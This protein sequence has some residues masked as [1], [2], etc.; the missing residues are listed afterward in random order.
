M[1]S[2]K[3]IFLGFL[4]WVF[5]TA[6]ASTAMAASTQKSYVTLRDGVARYTEY[7]PPSEGQPTVILINGLVYDLSRWKPYS[8]QL[9][10]AGFGVLNYYFRGQ[11]LTLRKEAL[12]NHTP[13][14]F[15]TGLDS[16]ALG[17]ELN[18]L[19]VQ[20]KL[21][22]P[23]V[24]V[25]LSY[26]SNIAAQFAVQNPRK[27]SQLVLMSPL[28]QPLSNYDPA[29]L[30]L[31]WNLEQI[32][33]WWGPVFGPAFYEMA[34]AQIY[35]SYLLQR[36][37]P[38]RI[39]KELADMP[40]V[41]KES[42]F[43]LVRAV[44]DFDLKKYRFE[45]LPKGSVHFL[46]GNEDNRQMFTDQIKAFNGTA[47]ASKGSL[48]YLAAANHAIPD[49]QGAIAAELTQLI[50]QRDSRLKSGATYQVN[51]KGQLAPATIK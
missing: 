31:T 14:F 43:H 36:I 9:K 45:T 39:P 18:S 46:L 50:F 30:W 10:K 23:F 49:S 1:N 38:E 28:V 29:G 16:A 6:S 22:G 13:S 4:S 51:A 40:E 21:K 33:F 8:Q 11:H 44:R 2:L 32:R 7:T 35:K 41:Y 25:G 15:E 24:V 47:P 12:N 27:V 17:A 3:N 42:I 26:G 5:V 20:M 34:Y 48:I 37:A 19:I